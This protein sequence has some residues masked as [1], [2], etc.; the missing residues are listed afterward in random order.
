[1]KTLFCAPLIAA[2]IFSCVLPAKAAK[3]D[4][5]Y[6]VRAVSSQAGA[7]PSEVY[8]HDAEGK[9]SAGKLMVKTFLNHQ[10]DLLETKGGAV[11]FSSKPDPASAKNEADVIGRCELPA[12]A[13][14][15]ILF[16]APESPGQPKCKVTVIDASA[17]EFPAGS[18]KVVNLSSLPIRIELEADKYEFKPGETKVIAKPP[19]GDAG[20]AGMKAFCQRDGKWDAISSGIWPNP[21]DKRVLQVISENTANKQ[22]EIV[23][24]RDVAKP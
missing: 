17:K 8:V 15:L 22:V 19:M 14:S 21:G 13:A 11:V 9:T 20:A 6:R 24:I 7:V 16:F 4:E 12:K 3:A 1:M 10:F 18:F 5:G 23:G 2:A